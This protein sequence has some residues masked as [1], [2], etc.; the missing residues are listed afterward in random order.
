MAL[1]TDGEVSSIEDLRGHDTQLLEV[2]NVEGIDV[3]RKLQLAQEEIAAEVTTLL[4]RLNYPPAASRV[5][6]TPTLKL[7]HTYLT[8][9]M[10]YRDAYRSQLN[11]RYA[12]KRDEFHGMV[13]WAY[14][15]VI[16][17]GLGMSYDPVARA[18]SPHVLPVSGG[19]PDGSY[20]V[21]A[22]WTNAAGSEGAVS[23]PVTIEIAGSSFA[24][25]PGAAPPNAK[26]WNVYAGTG[27]EALTLQNDTPLGLDR[28][29]PQPNTIANGGHSAGSGQSPD[30]LL[31][32]PR[33]ILRG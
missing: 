12:G 4:G 6:V 2:A 14:D 15:K 25:T 16:Q 20:F 5:V 26:G 10:V 11:D 30:Y 9:E 29:W 13:K 23:T 17:T 1:F 27:P 22:T 24:V 7:W 33:T 32:V 19:L 8:L 28:A 21:A 18:A 31:P 3:T